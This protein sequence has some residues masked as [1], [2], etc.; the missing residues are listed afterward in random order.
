MRCNPW[1][2]LWGLLPI[3]M[4]SW[5]A[6]LGHRESIENDLTT[7]A[8]S[9]LTHSGHSWA[10]VRFMGRDGVLTGQTLDETEP[11]KAWQ[12]IY[13]T[14]G[15]RALDNQ[16]GLIEKVDRY[17][18]VATRNGDAIRLEGQV[19]SEAVRRD[20]GQMIRTAIPGA[21]LEDKMVLARGAPALDLWLSSVALAVRQLVHLKQGKIDLEPTTL[22]VAGEAV[23]ARAYDALRSALSSELPKGVRLKQ[24][25]VR[26]PPV[27][28]YLWSARWARNQLVLSGHVPGDLA[29]RELHALS[30]RS[31]PRAKLDDRMVFAEG[32]PEAY[33]AATELTLRELA[34]LEE[35]MVEIAD[36]TY[37]I[38]G[39]AVSARLANR[40]RSALQQI[41]PAM[42]VSQRITTRETVVSPYVTRAGLE[43]GALV[44]TGHVPS[45]AARSAILLLAGKAAAGR[46]VRDSLEI[47]SGEPNGWQRCMELGFGALARLGNGQS[48]L[49]D[50]RLQLV[51]TAQ[52]ESL[53][54][55]VAQ[56]L[57]DAARDVCELSVKLTLAPQRDSAGDEARRRLE[58]TE[59]TRA[60]TAA[61]A[62]RRRADDEAHRRADEEAR[63]ADIS[64]EER[65]ADEARRKAEEAAHA[66]TAAVEE[67]RRVQAALS[68]QSTMR[69][70]AR[71]GVIQFEYAKSSINASSHP[72]LD[73]IADV[74]NRCPGFK[75]EIAGHTDSDGASD[76]NQRLSERR[77]RAVLD[78]LVRAGVGADRLAAMGYGET[79]PSAPNDTAENRAVNRRIEF[80]VSVD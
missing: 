10:M 27:K 41:P 51:G 75:I 72:T 61:E 49:T 39:I 46:P 57:R 9:V 4:M 79:R 77:A 47:G 23:D 21:K 15:V 80:S 45:D 5:V 73:R 50:D 20:I 44:L 13:D 28:P 53:A 62:T 37:S 56:N 66:R 18:W 14:W 65:R 55:S 7:R 52:S 16:T 67:Q 11:A 48:V 3:A 63:A 40:V 19:P 38:T 69:T 32:A 17:A 12:A 76:H 8:K 64:A 1:R 33:Q 36:A 60:A 2:W 71:E 25:A 74:A 29:R 35:A 34:N 58:E 42:R 24:E 6:V 68:C 78:Y 22:S 54:Q 30:Q 43:D 26:P 31:L 59:R 70:A